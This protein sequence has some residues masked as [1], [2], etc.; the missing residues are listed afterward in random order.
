MHTSQFFSHP[1]KPRYPMFICFVVCGGGGVWVG[2]VWGEGGKVGWG[3]SRLV[4]VGF[5]T[6]I[7]NNCF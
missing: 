6:P 3:S 1:V 7:Q 2:L 5:F 4:V